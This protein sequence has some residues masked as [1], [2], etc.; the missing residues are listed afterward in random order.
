M[1]QVKI[2]QE[3][4]RRSKFRSGISLIESYEEDSSLSSNAM[5]LIQIE[6]IK[7][8]EK[9]GKYS[10]SLDIVDSLLNNPLI[11]SDEIIHSQILIE[12]SKVLFSM[13]DMPGVITNVEIAEQKI[14]TLKDQDDPEIETMMASLILIRGGYYWHNGEL[15]NALYYFKLNLKVHEKLQIPL[16]LAHAY[17]NIGVLYNAIGDLNLA[18]QF[19]KIAYRMYDKIASTRG[20]SKAG[21]NI[22][23]IL[24]QLGDLD[25]ALSYMKKSLEIDIV[26]EYCDGIRVASHNMGE[27]YWHKGD[28]RKAYVYLKQSMEYCTKN[29]DDFHTTETLVPMIAVALNLH[30]NADVKAYSDQ[31][32]QINYRS[33]NKIIHQRFL[34]A[35]ALVL[36]KDGQKSSLLRAETNLLRIVQDKVRYHDVSQMARTYLDQIRRDQ[37][38]HLR[39][40]RIKKTY[41]NKSS[42]HDPIM[43]EFIK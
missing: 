43:E 25:E 37:K 19:L 3:L 27:V 36:M 14:F 42:K 33:E 18:L 31:L 39:N 2:L 17:N 22:G 21:N 12:R 30:L 8:L 10:E 7:F 6:K 1:R 26:D 41:E 40:L 9:L 15:D 32:S 11:C 24:I 4:F 34:L 29:K 20:F 5:T 23:A 13:G 16:E 38:G 28:D 35:K